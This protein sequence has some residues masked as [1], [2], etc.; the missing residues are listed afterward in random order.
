LGLVTIIKTVSTTTISSQTVVS[1]TD[2]ELHDEP[3]F[4]VVP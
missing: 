1:G 4:V 2:T 3:F